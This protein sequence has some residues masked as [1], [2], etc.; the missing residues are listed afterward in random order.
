M[1]SPNGNYTPNKFSGTRTPSEI[2]REAMTE[3]DLEMKKK[4]D[5]LMSMTSKRFVPAQITVERTV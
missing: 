3:Y 2:E 1:K 5:D 4:Q